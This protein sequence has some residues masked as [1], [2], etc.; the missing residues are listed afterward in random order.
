MT[1]TRWWVRTAARWLARVDGVSGQLRLAML[2][3]TGVSTATLTLQ[4]YGY[5]EFAWPLIGVTA[6]FGL[7]FAW[8]YSEGGVWNQMARDRTEMSANYAT[9]QARIN[10]E[11]TARAILAALENECL[12]D[13]QREAISDEL[14]QAFGEYWDGFD[15]DETTAD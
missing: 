7:A 6:G 10:T 2:G 8:A 12:D 5:A 4:S 15:I 9:P 1:A 13:N 3:M 11:M 14:D